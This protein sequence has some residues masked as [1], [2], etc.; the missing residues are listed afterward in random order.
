MDV[1]SLKIDRDAPRPGASGKQRRFL[2]PL[3]VLVLL[4]VLFFVFQR[5]LLGFVD[6]MRLPEVRVQKVVMR[7][8]AQSSVVGGTASNG[9][10][11]A[12]TRAALSADTPGR[13]VEMRVQEGSVVKK[14]DVVARLFAD[15]YQA[16]FARAEAEV[17]VADAGVARAQADVRVSEQELA[18]AEADARSAAAAELEARTGL[19]LAQIEFDRAKRLID[20]GVGNQERLDRAKNGLD[21]ARARLTTL[22]APV[23]SAGKATATCASRLAVSN[24]AVKEAEARIASAQAARDLSKVTLDK[25][26]VKAPFDG[27]VVLKDAE[28]GEVVSPNVQ[29]GSNAR[30]SVVTMVDFA[31]LEVQAEVP[32][33]NLGGVKLG[34]PARIWLDAYPEKSYP[35]RVDR[36]WPTANRSKATV[37]VR[38]VF[39]ER[40]DRLRPEMGARVV[41]VED[42]SAVAGSAVV[43]EP[44]IVIQSD[45]VVHVE[46]A[47]HVFV[48]ERDLV[49]LR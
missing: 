7:S 19:D 43:A 26:E 1:E 40:D 11:V 48:L 36:I 9:Y 38:V 37:E 35:G 41:F 29:G 5:Q 23:E 45:A 14:G 21:A 17:R 46:G 16:A 42:P 15:E 22:A 47:D 39:E 24:S 4:A 27:I 31:T 6:S 8:P 25:T 32:E 49:R 2:G 33:T 3:V 13:I 28:V 34:A 12:R 20:A 44:V 18:R 10:I 30:G